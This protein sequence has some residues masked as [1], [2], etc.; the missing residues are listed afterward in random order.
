[1]ERTC[2]KKRPA[3]SNYCLTCDIIQTVLDGSAVCLWVVL[4]KLLFENAKQAGDPVVQS[5]VQDELQKD[6]MFL[7]RKQRGGTTSG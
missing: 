7:G 6:H 3:Q 5:H 4:I 1:M 2:L